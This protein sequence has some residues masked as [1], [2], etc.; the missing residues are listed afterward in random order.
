MRIAAWLAGASILGTV[1]AGCGSS[2]TTTTEG[3]PAVEWAGS[4]CTAVTSYKSSL[5][6]IRTGLK[7]NVPSRSS[8]HQAGQDAKSATSDFVDSLN[9]LGKPGTAAGDKAEQTLDKLA[10]DLRKQADTVNVATQAD[11][12]ALEAVS[13]VST[14]LVTAGNHVKTAL[15]DLRQLEP[16]GELEQAFSTAPSCSSLTAG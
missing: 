13:V 8:L 15:D 11:T 9:G 12:G 14:A 3:S 16:K 6:D 2:S 4:L 5:T 7:A 10:A 1:L